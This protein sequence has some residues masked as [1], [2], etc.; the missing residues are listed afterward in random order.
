[1]N[2]KLL[3]VQRNIDKIRKSSAIPAC[4]V[5]EQERQEMFKKLSMQLEEAK[6]AMESGK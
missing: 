3:E 1:M 2:N 4:K 6:K 5:S